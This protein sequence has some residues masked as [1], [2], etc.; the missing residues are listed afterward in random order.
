[1]FACSFLK[2]PNAWVH[3]QGGH[4]FHM[5]TAWEYFQW[6]LGNQSDYV[7][8]VLYLP[9]EPTADFWLVRICDLVK[10]VQV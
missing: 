9:N 4:A 6:L 10:P 7:T 8:W 5:S 1:M 2:T 3:C